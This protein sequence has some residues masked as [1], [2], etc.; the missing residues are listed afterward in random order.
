[1]LS[2][3][4]I[5]PRLAAGFAAT[6]I[7]SCAVGGFA[8]LRMSQVNAN[9]RDLATNW[10]PSTRSLG[11]LINALNLVRRSEINTVIARN[12]QEFQEQSKRVASARKDAEAAWKEYEPMI[13]PGEEQ[14]LAQAIL[15]ALQAYDGQRTKVLALAARGA[16]ARDESLALYTGDSRKVFATLTNAI[17]ADI[18]LQSRGGDAAYVQSQKTFASAQLQVG[19]L[20][21]LAIA[22]SALMAWRITLSITGPLLTAVRVSEAVAAGDLQPFRVEATNDETGQLLR[23]LGAMH[24]SLVDVVSQVRAGSDSIVTGSGQ[25][26]AGNAD[27]SQRTEEQASNLQQ[28]AAS[29]EQITSTVRQNADNAQAA[30]RLASEARDFAGAGRKTVEDVVRTMGQIEES[31]R[32]VTDIIGVIDGIA[33]QTNILA[34]NAAVEAARAGEQ[35]RGFAVVAGEVRTLAQRSAAAAK[36]IKTL[37]ETSASTVAA[38]TSLVGQAGTAIG[39]IAGKVSNVHDLVSE[40]ANAS[41]EQSTGIGQVGDAVA[42]LDQVTQQNAALVEESAA[43]AESLKQQA[44]RLTGVVGFF[45]L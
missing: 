45:R 34:L 38:G 40:I 7:L 17:Q 28:T 39:Q 20:L 25:I 41:A 3:L 6:L 19:G 33:F 29:M 43:A 37:I 26:A 14:Q 44:D 27:L 10:L 8:L 21:A 2:R 9:T 15:Q 32:K 36:E 24:K 4:K 13:T 16:E 1:M 31:S 12:P 5:G 23:S 18:D 35:G 22:I 30:M 42:Q 11:H